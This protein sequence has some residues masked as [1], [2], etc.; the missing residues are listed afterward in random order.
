MFN[1][2]L[3]DFNKSK[4]YDIGINLKRIKVKI[5]D[6]VN[7]NDFRQRNNLKNYNKNYYF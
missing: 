5:S 1:L 2:Y 6:M 3:F 4:K 7:K